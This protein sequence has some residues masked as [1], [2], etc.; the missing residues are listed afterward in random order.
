[1]SSPVFIVDV[2]HPAAILDGAV[3]MIESKLPTPINTSA[4]HYAAG[5]LL[6]KTQEHERAAA[7]LRSFLELDTPEHRDFQPSAERMLQ[8]R[9]R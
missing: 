6:A 8:D 9:A 5:Y 2:H 3:D 7:H 1:L 4:G